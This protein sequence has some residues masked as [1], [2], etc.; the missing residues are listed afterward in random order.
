MK[1][2]EEKYITKIKNHFLKDFKVTVIDFKLQEIFPE[3]FPLTVIRKFVSKNT[4]MEEF[5]FCN[6]LD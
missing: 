5:T 1:K 4:A 2:P 6:I 3:I